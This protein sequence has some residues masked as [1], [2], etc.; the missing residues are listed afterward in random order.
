[1]NRPLIAAFDGSLGSEAAAYWAAHEAVR[2]H[3]PLRL[4]HV[5][6][7]LTAV[8]PAADQHRMLAQIQHKIQHRCPGLVVETELVEGG[9]V[10]ET[11]ATEAGSGGALVLGTRGLG[12]FAELLIGS[13]SL[14]T[15]SCAPAPVIVVPSDRQPETPHAPEIVVGIDTLDASAAVI[16]FALNEAVL[17]GARLRAVHGW[18][19][20]PSW[21][22]LGWAPPIAPSSEGE[23]AEAD[24]LS[25][26]MEGWRERF[27]D[28]EIIE[29]LRIC[30][31]AA[32]LVDASAWADLVV[33]GRRLRPH[34][35]AGGLGP[36]AHAVIHHSQAAIA[37]VPHP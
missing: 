32:A 12:G 25:K 1:M 4:I 17:H 14:E 2:R 28:T 31:P 16:E 26:A 36:V 21:S 9:R 3:S 6:P 34:H 20:P 35:P 24:L 5:D 33:V 23:A 19:L 37:V 8:T 27:P 22:S 11:L 7:W 18:D 29:D 30:S 10:I 13:V 15:A